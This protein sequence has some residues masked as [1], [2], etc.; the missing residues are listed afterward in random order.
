[1]GTVQWVNGSTRLCMYS[2][3]VLLQPYMQH[4]SAIMMALFRKDPG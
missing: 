3:V 2:R 1:M 4:N